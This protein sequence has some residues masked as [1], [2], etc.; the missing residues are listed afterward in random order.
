MGTMPG[1]LVTKLAIH[2]NHTGVML[3]AGATGVPAANLEYVVRLI[4]SDT[5]GANLTDNI[6]ND[7]GQQEL[8]RFAASDGGNPA[9]F[10]TVAP[11]FVIS[12]IDAN[13]IFGQYLQL[14][15][16]VPAKCSAH[17]NAFI[18]TEGGDVHRAYAN[19][20]TIL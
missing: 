1:T 13:K 8:A 19:R 4:S 9:K 18:A 11:D 15:V 2:V 14:E 6:G 5:V 7:K 16:V 3:A 20:R 10:I 17:I 12:K